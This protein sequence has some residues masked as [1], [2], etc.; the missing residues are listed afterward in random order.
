MPEGQV[1]DGMDALDKVLGKV[2]YAA[3][4][5][6][7]FE[8]ALKQPL[9]KL[10]SINRFLR[11]CLGKACYTL[12]RKQLRHSKGARIVGTQKCNDNHDLYSCIE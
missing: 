10:V 3:D 9:R 7:A 2:C 4:L 6:A 5:L 8:K 12:I 1:G 11:M